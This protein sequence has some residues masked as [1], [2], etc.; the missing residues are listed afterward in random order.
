MTRDPS[1]QF[2]IILLFG[3]LAQW[4]AWRVRLPSILMLLGAGFLVG[5]VLDWV[6]PDEL[7]GSALLPI[8]SM[9]VAIILFEGGLS[10]RLDELRKVGSE[11]RNLLTIGVVTTWLLVGAAAHLVAGVDIPIALILGALLTVTGPTVILPM[12]RH[13][14]PQGRI[15]SVLRWEGIASDPIGALLAVLVFEFVVAAEEH[16]PTMFIVSGLVRTLLIGGGIGVAT[17]LVLAAGMRRYWIPDYLF[18]PLSLVAAVLAFWSSNQMQGEAGLLAAMVAGMTLAHLEPKHA[19]HILHF[20]EDIRVLL[21]SLLFIVLSA[22][23][24]PGDFRALMSQPTILFVVALILIVRPCAVAL[25]FL[26]TKTSWQQ[27][28]F[29]ATM[30]PRGIVAAAVSSVFS[31]HLE[32][33]GHAEAMSLMFLTFAAIIGTVSFYGIMA[34]PV[35]R[36][37]GLAEDNPQGIL[38][39][40]AQPWVCELARVLSGLKF[41]V[42]LIDTNFDNVA[43]AKLRG[44]PAFRVSAL[45]EHAA[46]TIDLG[47]IGRLLAVTAN[48]EVNALSAQ[49]FARLLGSPNVFQL[50]PD[51][52]KG[53]RAGKEKHLH[54]RWAFGNSATFESFHERFMNGWIPKAT[55]LSAEFDFAAFREK[56]GADALPLFIVTAQGRLTVITADAKTTPA[57]GQ[58][59]IALVPPEAVTEPAASSGE[60]G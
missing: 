2:V 30:A 38:F 55:K 19:K 16:N 20:K 22:R 15:S 36:R 24:A 5:P 60:A 28:C 52:E 37:L 51:P 54:G 6:R 4:V 18:N 43:A 29:A 46:D 23:F 57:A 32:A 58:T 33:A 39:V 26:G 53:S 9:S 45:E 50:P 40:G 1:F 25:S 27:R 21:V 31:L 11:V 59:L 7:L 3:A 8:V 44:L 42:L 56:H 12:L 41:R 48:D 49:Q 13:I 47:G 14:R 34:A 17:G 10:L 35:A